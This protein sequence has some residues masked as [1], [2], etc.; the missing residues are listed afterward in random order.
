MPQPILVPM[1]GSPSARRALE[2]ASLMQRATGAVVHLLHVPE[3]P[4]ADEHL[5]AMVGVPPMAATEEPDETR[6]LRLLEETWQ[7]L[8]NADGAVAY[9]IEYG[10]SESVIAEKA[11]ELDAQ[12]IVMGSRGLGNLKSLFVGSVSQKV[13]EL[14]PCLVITLHAVPEDDESDAV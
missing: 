13:M 10:D 3:P 8:G 4:A 1:D 2:H 12:C 7:T 11:R 9:H 6:G 5:G 14:A